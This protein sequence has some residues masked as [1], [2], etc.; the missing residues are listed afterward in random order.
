MPWIK[1]LEIDCLS[2]EADRTAP[3]PI[4]K[5]FGM[6]A[7]PLGVT[8]KPFGTTAKGFGATGKPFGM[9]DKTR[10]GVRPSG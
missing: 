10:V 8:D 9:T 7:K 3:D 6:T 5:P 1:K 4:S 2:L